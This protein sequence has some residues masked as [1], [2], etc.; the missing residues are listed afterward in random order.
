MDH[1]L[2]EMSGIV[3][4]G[5]DPDTLVH[6]QDSGNDPYLIYTK[7]DGTILSRYLFTEKIA[8]TEELTRGDCPWGGSCIFVFDTGDNFH[9]RRT[10]SIWAIE[11]ASLR[12]AKIHS[13][14]IDFK[15]PKDEHLDVEAAV[16]IDKTFYLFA[17][18]PKHSRVFALGPSVWKGDG[19]TEASLLTDLPYTMITGASA[20][21]DG[22]R[23]LLINW[24]GVIELSK[25]DEKG[26]TK[27]SNDPWYPYRRRSKIHGLAQQE[28]VTYDK[29]Q[30]SFYYSSE[31][32]LF[33]DQEWGIM[34]AQCVP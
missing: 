1:D 14:K 19:Q 28:A 16:L 6:I 7:T 9:W 17:K 15:F 2:E 22:E 26:S 29:D 4:G 18:E 10:R 8:D 23:I 30:R 5:L 13:Q 27:V 20:S 12:S 33:S 31:K 34:H 11:E 3:L 25:S 24:Q 21:S 32:K